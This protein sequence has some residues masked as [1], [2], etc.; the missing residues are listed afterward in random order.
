MVLN[1]QAFID[2]SETPNGEFVL[3]GH[4]AAP[5]AWALFAKEWEELL[6]FGTLADNSKHYHFK[7]SEMAMTRE[8]MQRV[9]PF[10]NIIEKHVLVSMS[11]RLNITDFERAQRRA[12]DFL[13]NNM[14]IVID[15]GFW[16]NPY[17]FAFRMLVDRFHAEH[18]LFAK[19][20]HSDRNVDFIFDD[21]SEKAPILAAW[22]E[23]KSRQEAHIRDRFGATPRFENDREF[24]PLQAADLWVWW[25]RKWYEDDPGPSP[26]KMEALDFEEWSG[27][28]RSIVAISGDEEQ[29]FEYFKTLAM[30]N[31]FDDSVIKRPIIAPD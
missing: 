31:F 13:V 25:V 9:R 18:Q 5:E 2:E 22:D 27:R 24:L 17:Y 1:F 3:G 16:T 10:Y 14:K 15:F 6:P 26:A 8:R 20:L 29:I 23:Y 11:V 19:A 28:K 4:I 30:E 7:M 12:V 21:R